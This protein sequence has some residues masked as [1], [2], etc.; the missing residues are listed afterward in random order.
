MKT[1]KLISSILISIC[2]LCTFM[3]ASCKSKIETDLS[4]AMYKID[5][6]TA[7]G[8]E[9]GIQEIYKNSSKKISFIYIDDDK[10]LKNLVKS[11]EVQL[12]FTTAGNNQRVCSKLASKNALLTKPIEADYTSSIRQSIIYDDKNEVAFPILSNNFE[13][14]INLYNFRVSNV[15]AINNWDDVEKFLLTQIRTKKTPLYFS[16]ADPINFF[17]M[18]GAICEAVDGSQYYKEALEILDKGGNPQQ[19]A[20]DLIGSPTSPMVNTATL[21]KSYFRKG[22]YSKDCFNMNAKDLERY[23]QEDFATMMIMSLSEHRTFNYDSIRRFSSAYIPSTQGAA[24]RTFSANIIYAIPVNKHSQIQGLINKLVTDENQAILSRAT[25]LAPV[26]RNS[27]TPDKQS[28]DA[29]YWIAATNPPFA[30]LGHD[31]K[32][33]EKDLGKIKDYVKNILLYE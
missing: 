25:G 9:K 19:V 30:G 31:T 14:D 18:L 32:L 7:S 20:T 27:K 22:F 2:T 33:S 28:D 6:S 3:L 12:V 11:K 16:G 24:A 5:S 10:E 23:A 1:K 21:L 8:L 13:I 26:T 17:D 15:E 4:I 29:R